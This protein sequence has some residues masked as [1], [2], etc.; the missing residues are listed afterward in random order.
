MT[1][2]S[3]RWRQIDDRSKFI[4]TAFI[5]KAQNMFSYED[6]PYYNI[7]DL[8]IRLCLI[9][10]A[11]IGYW[12]MIANTD[13]FCPKTLGSNQKIMLPKSHLISKS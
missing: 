7:C 11:Q 6:N 3:T 2:I 4:V 12:S 8:I 10:Y 13:T 9:Y 1:D 5:R